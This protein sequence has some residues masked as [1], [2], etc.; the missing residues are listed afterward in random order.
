MFRN[1]SRSTLENLGTL[2]LI[3]GTPRALCNDPASHR[4]SGLTC[5]KQGRVEDHAQPAARRFHT[6]RRRRAV[7][8]MAVRKSFDLLTYPSESRTVG[9]FISTQHIRL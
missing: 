4:S 5:A 9:A 6:R 2:R 1:G 8:P 3:P 7:K